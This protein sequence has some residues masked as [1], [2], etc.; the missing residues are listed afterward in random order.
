ILRSALGYP[1][2]VP[3]RHVKPGQAGLI[4]GRNVGRRIQT[5][6]GGHGVSSDLAGANVGERID[7]LIEQQ[8]DL[9]P[10]QVLLRQVDA[11]V[12]YKL[13]LRAGLL[14]EEYAGDMRYAADTRSPC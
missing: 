13:Q 9:P 14:L 12:G 11:T 1:N 10:D 2:C 6:L 3:D 5:R 7:R 8:I 4:H